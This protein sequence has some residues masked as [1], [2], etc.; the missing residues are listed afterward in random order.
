[1]DQL[2][3]ELIDNITSFLPVCDLKYVLT[4]SKKFQYAAEISSGAF[5]AFELKESNT[6]KFVALYSG[7]R[8]PYLRVVELKPSF[9][10]LENKNIQEMSRREKDVY[11]TRQIKILLSALKEAERHHKTNI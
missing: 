5:Q 8:L 2:P 1:M 4:L 11:F 9:P 3:Q 6:E 10:K 7:H